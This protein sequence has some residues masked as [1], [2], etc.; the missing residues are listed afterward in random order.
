MYH[1][2]TLYTQT[3]HAI[4]FFLS[5]SSTYT[6]PQ[7]SMYTACSLIICMC[8]HALLLYRIIMVYTFVVLACC[9]S[10]QYSLT[11]IGVI[12]TVNMDCAFHT[13]T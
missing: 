10:V 4:I 12:K 3:V 2:Y 11:M 13:Q 5:C 1:K 6:P 8:N 7:V 9:C